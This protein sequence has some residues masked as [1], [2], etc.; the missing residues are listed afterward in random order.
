V[1]K[2]LRKPI[3]AVLQMIIDVSASNILDSSVQVVPFPG[4]RLCHR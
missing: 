4:G 1:P 3:A 2:E